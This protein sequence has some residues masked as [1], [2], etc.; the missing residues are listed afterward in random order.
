MGKCRARLLQLRS[1]FHKVPGGRASPDEASV[2]Y[3]AIDLQTS[4][5]PGDRIAT[6]SGG[7]FC[8][9]VFFVVHAPRPGTVFSSLAF[10]SFFRFRKSI[11]LKFFGSLLSRKT[12]KC[13]LR[14]S[15][16][17]CVRVP[18]ADSRRWSLACRRSRATAGGP[19]GP[20][21]CPEGCPRGCPAGGRLCR[22]WNTHAHTQ[23]SKAFYRTTW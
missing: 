23:G 3:R 1:L 10:L 15:S 12:G 22:T 20:R 13:G 11:S 4:P 16:V 7:C 6:A 8:S 21:G 14:H 5:G 9:F 18:S 2:N 19:R 17:K